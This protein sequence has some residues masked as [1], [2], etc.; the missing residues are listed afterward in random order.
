MSVRLLLV[1]QR[2]G[3]ARQSPATET[4]LVEPSS[5]CMFRSALQREENGTLSATDM[6]VDATLLGEPPRACEFH[7]SA[8]GL[9]PGARLT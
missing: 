8:P 1:F 4:S 3:H 9:S 5:Q 6:D 2:V 7:Q